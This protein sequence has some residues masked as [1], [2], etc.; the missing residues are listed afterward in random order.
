MALSVASGGR[1]FAVA[2]VL[3]FVLGMASLPVG[4]MWTRA[5]IL[6]VGYSFTLIGLAATFVA[7]IGMAEIVW[8]SSH[9]VPVPAAD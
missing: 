4:E 2:V 5:W 6:L 1:H 8:G 9:S 7:V 3:A